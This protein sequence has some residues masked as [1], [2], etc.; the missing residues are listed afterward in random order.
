M[1]LDCLLGKTDKQPN[2]HHKETKKLIDNTII[3][4]L[5]RTYFNKTP[6]P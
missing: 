3:Y 4:Q 1:K 2:S 5:S 6:K